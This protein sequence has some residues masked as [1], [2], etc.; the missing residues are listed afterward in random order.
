MW[1]LHWVHTATLERCETHETNQIEY[2]EERRKNT[3]SARLA[4]RLAGL[5]VSTGL[6]LLRGVCGWRWR[7]RVSP[8]QS[9]AQS[10]CA[11]LGL[12]VCA[13]RCWV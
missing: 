6:A 12:G 9:H 11:R 7:S 3:R 8:S 2:C 13:I 5:T 10:V 4:A 1:I